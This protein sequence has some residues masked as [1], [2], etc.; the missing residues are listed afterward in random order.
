MRQRFESFITGVTVCYKYIQRI[1]SME[2]T[3]LGLKG[4]HLTCLFYLQNHAQGLTAAQLCQLCAEDKASISRT[5]A[6]LKKRGYIAQGGS[7]NYRAPLTLTQEG[8]AAAKQLDPLINRWVMSGGD[9]LS[10]EHREIFYK[11]LAQI[12]ENLRNR[13]EDMEK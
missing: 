12:G 2:M 9:G 10:E 13:L 11:A 8:I 6:D 1:K 7:K 5:V 3:E 4:T